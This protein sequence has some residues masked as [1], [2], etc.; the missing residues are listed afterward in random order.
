MILAPKRGVPPH[1]L[2]ETGDIVGRD[3]AGRTVIQV[4]ADDWLLEQLLTFDGGAEDLEDNADAEP[5]ETV[6]AR[7]ICRG[8]R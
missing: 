1:H 3:D 5:D 4:A 7:R 6:P 2:L 8:R